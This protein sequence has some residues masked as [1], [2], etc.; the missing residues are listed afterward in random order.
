MRYQISKLC[1]C[2]ICIILSCL[3]ISYANAREKVEAFYYTHLDWSLLF[4]GN[5]ACDNIDCNWV[6]IT[7]ATYM[8][9]YFNEHHH[10]KNK[11]SLSVGVYNMHYLWQTH[12]QTTPWFCDVPADLNIAESMESQ[13]RFGGF[14]N[15]FQRFNGISL[16]NPKSTIP[17]IYSE[18]YLNESDF[19]PMKPYS[20][21]IKGG[22]FIAG[23]CHRRDSSN[24][25]RNSIVQQLRDLGFRIDG[26]GKCMKTPHI[27]EG[28]SLPTDPKYRYD[29]TVKRKAINNYLFYFAFEN[30]LEEGYVTEKPFDALYSGMVSVYIGDC[31]HLRNLLP[32]PKSVICTTDFSDNHELIKYLNYLMTNE[33]AYEIHRQ[34]RHSFNSTT[35]LSS[36]S[37]LQTS[38]NC[39][40]CQWAVKQKHHTNRG[41]IKARCLHDIKSIEKGFLDGEVVKI[42]SS[43]ETFYVK[44][45]TLHS[46]PNL[47]TLIA[48]H[49]TIHDVETL[50]DDLMQK[51]PKGDPLPSV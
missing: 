10:F 22:A 4:N 41:K 7:N 2:L 44:N 25:D 51:I 13:T 49:K 26:L 3:L 9:E 19:L 40:V 23:D 43:R 45:G 14:F 36:N 46:I 8:K 48:L 30:S 18:A 21:L 35:Y 37:Y 12:R 1:P 20:S 39:R 24:V 17:Q 32:D 27:P 34:W 15:Q 47:D 5:Y 33:T 28:I 50:P 11:S 6:S 42:H 38:W 16:T 29:L 31:K